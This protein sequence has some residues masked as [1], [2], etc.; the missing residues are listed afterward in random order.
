MIKYYGLFDIDLKVIFE[1]VFD[2]ALDVYFVTQVLENQPVFVNKRLVFEISQDFLE[3]LKLF[4]AY[5]LTLLSKVNHY[6]VTISNQLA[7][8]VLSTFILT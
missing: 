6:L 1:I 8:L 5:A 3:L 7:F 2:L 4:I